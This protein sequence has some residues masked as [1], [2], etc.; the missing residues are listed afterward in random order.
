MPWYS[1]GTV[2]V[3]NGSTAVTADGSKFIG[4]VKPGDIFAVVNDGHIYEIDQIVSATQL[5][6]KRPY[7]GADG[8]GLGYDIIPSATFL[9]SLAAQVADLIALYNAVPQG[10]AD[11]AASAEAAA[12]SAAAAAN[13]ATAAASSKDAAAASATAS[14]KSASAAALS[15]A[16]ASTSE[17]NAA[18]SKGAAATS[19]TNAK[20][21]ESNAA[22]SAAA[23]KTSETN[24]KASESVTSASQAAAAAAATN[25][26]TSETNAA[27]SQSAAATAAS[28]AKASETNAA[29]SK[30]AAA[31]AASNA[32]TSETNAAASA[33]SIG[34]AETNAKAS[35]DAAA[36]SAKDAAA[37]AAVASGAMTNALTKA[38]N[39]SDVTDKAAARSN[40]D[41]PS[42]AALTDLSNSKVDKAGGRVTGPLTLG[43]TTNY[44]RTV[45]DAN[46]YTPSIQADKAANQ[47][48]FVNAANSAYNL[49]VYDGGQVAT[50]GSLTVGGSSVGGGSNATYA[51]DGNVYG[52][53]WGGWLS[54][55]LNANKASR[56]GETIFGRYVFSNQG[57]QADLAL[58]NWRSG[59]DAWVYLRARD[60]GGLEVI[61]SAYNAVPWN[62]SNDG[63]TWQSNNL[64]V[65]GATFQTD[66]N[67]IIP[68]RGTNLFSWLDNKVD[69]GAQC[70]H[71][72]ADNEFGSVNVGYAGNRVVAGSP[73]VLQGLRSQAGSNVTFLIACWLRV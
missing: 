3:T 48:G 7:A 64:H 67:V 2:A 49:W 60:G 58:H 8:T 9:K 56:A 13:S 20:T 72:G 31:T 32:K 15:E 62:V 27:A 50:R 17:A 73:W 61:N 52:S 70:F 69:H 12:K 57:W 14:A 71:G 39:L 26:K 47:I 1:T 36:K 21:A 41:V 19:A 44:S 25:A 34:N 11:S 66:G 46:G 63:E 68:G 55:W 65:G 6:L 35:A 51:T 42:N 22:N 33:N 5:T 59:Q 16:H 53:V 37:S 28:N 38:N 30:N 40:L 4:N 24:A 23:A 45:W 29:A 54:N 18:A 10:V 43:S